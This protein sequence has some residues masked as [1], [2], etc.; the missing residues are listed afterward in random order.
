MRFVWNELILF[1]VSF[2]HFISIPFEFDLEFR[3]VIVEYLFRS[4][5]VDRFLFWF[6]FTVHRLSFRCHTF[7][8]FE[9]NEKEN[10]SFSKYETHFFI[11][12]TVTFHWH[13][14][15]DSNVSFIISFNIVFCNFQQM[16]SCRPCYLVHLMFFVHTP[17]WY[18]C[19]STRP[20]SYPHPRILANHYLFT[21]FFYYYTHK[22]RHTHTEHSNTLAYTRPITHAFIFIKSKCETTIPNL[23][24]QFA[25]NETTTHPAKCVNIARLPLL[26]EISRKYFRYSF[27]L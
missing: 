16:H 12:A 5:F 10:I 19:P 26:D 3:T 14:P 9:L 24:R 7:F 1:F 25:R 13:L 27:F 20:R 2:F 11:R 8:S 23:C 6:S 21:I 15:L 18:T 4:Y 17:L 22:H